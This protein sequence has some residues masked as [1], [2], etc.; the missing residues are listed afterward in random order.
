MS[1]VPPDLQYAQSAFLQSQVMSRS[2]EIWSL[3]WTA[4]LVG[5]PGSLDA[6]PRLTD[7]VV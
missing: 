4:D 1:F 5:V 7:G 6:F 2:D 3:D